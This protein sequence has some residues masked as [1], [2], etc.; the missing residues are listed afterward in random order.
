MSS[1]E[2][3]ELAA[4]LVRIPSHPGVER[5]EERVARALA[6]WLEARGVA[7][8]LD[9]VA[10]GRPN[11][12]ATVRGAA[13]GWHLLLCGHTDTVPLNRDG[14]GYG[15]SGEIVAGELR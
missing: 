11:L 4:E 10:P 9:E 15:F 7:A 2:V 5:R 8:R 1:S 3:V 12:V 13:P 6:E 14:A